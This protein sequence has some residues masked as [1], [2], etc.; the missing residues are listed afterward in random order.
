[1]LTS[2]E[3]CDELRPMV[4]AGCRMRNSNSRPCSRASTGPELEAA[5]E[6]VVVVVVEEEEEEEAA[7]AVAAEEAAAPGGPAGGGG[8]P[9]G[10]A[11]AGLQGAERSASRA[12]APLLSS[13]TSAMFPGTERASV[14]AS[15]AEP[16]GRSGGEEKRGGA[17]AEP[18]CLLLPL[19][20]ASPPA[21]PGRARPRQRC[22]GGPEVV[23]A[24]SAAC[25]AAERS[26]PGL[27]CC[28]SG[29]RA[30]KRR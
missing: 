20:A 15:G 29:E 24:R 28:C 27:G 14:P 25:R 30:S 19:P 3:P 16:A 6:E 2:T 11:A 22:S 10:G 7:A 12:R 1:M 17:G 21:P 5:V 26:L 18:R 23:G 4:T 9:G 13:P 8:G